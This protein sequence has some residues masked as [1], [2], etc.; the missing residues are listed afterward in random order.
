MQS[1]LSRHKD[2][3]AVKIDWIGGNSVDLKIATDDEAVSSIEDLI[4]IFWGS[5][6]T[7]K[8]WFRSYFFCN[9]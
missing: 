3:Y 2:L 7:N 1:F 8:N 5:S 6:A 9:A 4:N